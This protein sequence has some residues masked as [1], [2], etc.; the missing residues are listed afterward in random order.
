MLIATVFVLYRLGFGQR[1]GE[2]Y[3]VFSAKGDGASLLYDTLKALGY[4]VAPSYAPADAKMNPNDAYLII[5]PLDFTGEDT[6]QIVEWAKRG[7]RMFFFGT[8]YPTALDYALSEGFSFYDIDN[9]TVYQVGVGEI[10]TGYAGD[11]ANAPLMADSYYG[12]VIAYILDEWDAQN[13]FFP[14]YYHGYRASENFFSTLPL[15]VKLC[16][17]QLIIFAGFFMWRLGK[18]FGKPVPYYEETERAGDEH[19]RALARL[20]AAAAP[21]KKKGALHHHGDSERNFR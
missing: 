8:E 3:S 7:G 1:D 14:E 18:R 13:V 4:P 17:Y 6:A 12:E 5:N 15:I 21:R 20:Y 16:A 19:V 10:I 2:A 9:L 11:V